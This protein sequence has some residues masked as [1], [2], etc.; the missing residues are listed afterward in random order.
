MKNFPF[1]KPHR[2]EIIAPSPP[3]VEDRGDIWVTHVRGGTRFPQETK[4][5]RFVTKIFFADHSGGLA[6]S[7]AGEIPKT[8]RVG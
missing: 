8:L 5:R 4:P 6:A 3:K 1:H 2:I 7:L